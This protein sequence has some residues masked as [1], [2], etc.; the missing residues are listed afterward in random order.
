MALDQEI[1]RLVDKLYHL[2]PEEIK[3]VEDRAQK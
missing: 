1:D 3:L 2:T